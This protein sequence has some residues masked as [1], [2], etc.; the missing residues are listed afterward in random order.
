MASGFFSGSETALFSLS[1]HQRLQLDGS[2]HVVNRTI[3]RLLAETRSLLITLLL[4]NMTVNVIYFVI[5]SVLL[6]QAGQLSKITGWQLSIL[7]ILPL[8]TLIMLGEVI[9][10]LIA[11]NAPLTITRFIAVP[12]FIIHRMLGP[13]RFVCLHVVITPLARL[14]SPPEKPTDISPEELDSLL[15]LSQRQGLID[16]NE[17]KLLQQVLEL[18]QLKV[19]DLMRPRVDIQ[20]YNLQD[21]PQTLINL[22]HQ[23]KLHHLPVFLDNIDHVRG[24][25][26]SREVLLNP[27]ADHDQ[28]TTLIRKVKYV[29]EQQ[30]ADKLLVELRNTGTTFALVVDEY[31]GTAGL[32]T[33]EDVVEHM[34]GDI[35]GEYETYR[36]PQVRQVRPGVW[37]ADADLSVR[38]WAN[39]F[40]RRAS[41]N[42]PD[43]FEA[44]NTIGGLVMAMLGRPARTGDAV[45]M[46]NVR[47]SVERVAGMRIRNVIIQLTNTDF[48][49]EV[50]LPTP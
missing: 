25:V 35:P 19:R 47:I 9:P 36:Q 27:P 7:G 23:T 16:S 37:L 21:P 41:I 48:A 33:I 20:A 15:T 34:L 50:Q 26:Y 22:I 1:R 18:G 45:R 17:E 30:R 44:V 40:G 31:G 14:I 5:S 2:K 38:D 28:I 12:L 6:I 13:V 29:P 43:M 24:I 49:S 32:I 10:K 39:V 46:G 8:L 42:V 3:I 11:A 4:G